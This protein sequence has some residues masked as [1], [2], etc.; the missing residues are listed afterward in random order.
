MTGVL[1]GHQL[2][3]TGTDT[4]RTYFLGRPPLAVL[5]VYG[6]HTILCGV[7]AGKVDSHGC[8]LAW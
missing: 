2:T 7:G 5:T 8:F 3:G 1:V 4:P 6:V